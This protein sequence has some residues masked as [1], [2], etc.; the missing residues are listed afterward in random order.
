MTLHPTVVFELLEDEML[1]AQE[2][3]GGRI[4]SLNRTGTSVRCTFPHP[5]GGTVTLRLDGAGY[6]NE[7]FRCAVV[8]SA[9]EVLP[10]EAWPPGLGHS[11]HPV[12]VRP[13]ACVQ[14]TYEYHCL[15]CH[16]EDA[17]DAHRGRIRMVDLLDHLLRRAGV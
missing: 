11:V 12:L 8:S 10:L 14:G 15:P 1:V 2:R 13:F 6:D 16:M 7:P 4:S 5:G 17:W 3:L 9:D